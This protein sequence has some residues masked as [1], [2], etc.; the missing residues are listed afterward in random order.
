[1]WRATLKPLL[2][3]ILP[4]V[5]RVIER[6]SLDIPRRFFLKASQYNTVPPLRKDDN[7]I[8]SASDIPNLINSV[9]QHHGRAV[10]IGPQS[11][12]DAYETI[13]YRREQRRRSLSGSSEMGP[14]SPV[15]ESS[16]LEFQSNASRE[17]RTGAGPLHVP[18]RKPIHHSSAVDASPI[19]TDTDLQ[20][21]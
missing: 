4:P 12:A 9:R 19:C 20:D 8:P 3:R 2:F 6:L 1:A 13:A 15:K 11:A 14:I 10:S 5:F 16:K 7:V 21:T 17:A 18:T